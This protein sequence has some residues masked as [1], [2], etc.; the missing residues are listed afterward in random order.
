M[1]LSQ[2]I[3]G[4]VLLSSIIG[5]NTGVMAQTSAAD[6]DITQKPTALESVEFEF[7]EYEEFILSNGLKVFAIEDKEAP[8]VEFRLL[9]PG[10]SAMDKIPGQADFLASLL[11]KGYGKTSARQFADMM[12]G[13]GISIGSSAGTESFSISGN[14]LTAHQDIMWGGLR[15]IL[16]QASLPED[17]LDKLKPQALQGLKSEKSNPSSMASK[18]SRKVIFGNN[19]PYAQ[20]MDEA[21]IEKLEIEDIRS[22]YNDYIKPD[23]ASILVVGDITA[24]K[25]KNKLEDLFTGWTGAAQSVN[26]VPPAVQ[27]PVG[28]YF[29]SRPGSVQSSIRYLA[30]TTDYID[31]DRDVLHLTSGIISGGFS[32]RLFKTLREKHSYTYSPTGTLTNYKLFNYLMAGS[33]VRNSVTDSAIVV[34]QNEIKDLAENGPSESELEIMKKYQ[35]GNYNMSFEDP[36]FAGYIVQNAYF[37]GQP[38]EYAKQFT[39]RKAAIT[40]GKIKR[41]V[42]EYLMPEQAYLVVVG[43]PSVRESLVQFGKIYDYNTDV[44]PIEGEDAVM[45]KTSETPDDIIEDYIDAIGGQ[46]A[47]DGIKNLVANGSLVLN[48]AGQEYKGDFRSQKIAD[49]RF[50]T[51]MVLPGMERKVIYNGTYMKSLDNGIP[52]MIQGDKMKM[53]AIEES[54]FPV[55]S[56]SKSQAELTT[57]GEQNGKYLLKAVHPNNKEQIFYFDKETGLLTKFTENMETQGGMIE[58]IHYMNDYREFQGVRLPTIKEMESTSF[59]NI[60][61]LDY[62]VNT[63]IDEKDFEIER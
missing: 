37:K 27:E 38:V 42:K 55:I 32:G 25:L 57:L 62:T 17:E 33:D 15:G 61:K 21:D 2:K 35:I 4:L 1:R 8:I 13:K 14:S 63:D 23:G 26:S 12:D 29:I 16:T 47:I 60:I 49:G 40:D 54:I 5:F 20:T 7:P 51:Q 22:Y 10:G 3:T 45:K 46:D 9:I 56:L 30:P 41:A 18:L 50:I 39:K 44:M 48:I 28:V 19:H 52:D 6:I 36:S 53:T 43:D 11:T 59:S 58:A 31:K 34:I 24:R